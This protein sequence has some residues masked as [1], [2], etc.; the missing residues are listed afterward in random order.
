MKYKGLWMQP[1]IGG[2]IAFARPRP[3]T[4]V[5]LPIISESSK[6][7]RTPYSLCE[8]VS[9]TGPPTLTKLRDFLLPFAEPACCPWSL[10][11][12]EPQFPCQQNQVVCDVDVIEGFREAG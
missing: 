6:M 8:G 2:A 5:V 7:A 12:S 11:W 9:L 3:L 1:I 4:I 10:R